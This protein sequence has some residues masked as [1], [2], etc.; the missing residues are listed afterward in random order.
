MSNNNQKQSV[1]NFNRDL[2]AKMS[3]AEVGE[4][5]SQ[6]KHRIDVEGR[7]GESTKLLETELCYIQDE[8]QRRAKY[9]PFFSFLVPQATS[10]EA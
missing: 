8:A 7:R 9:S 4:A 5:L 6:F 2:L 10:A 3:D 1:P